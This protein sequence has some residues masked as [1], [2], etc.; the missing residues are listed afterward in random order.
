MKPLEM[1]D[2]GW[3]DEDKAIVCRTLWGEPEVVATSTQRTAIPTRKF[4]SEIGGE[5]D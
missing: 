4:T 1:P 3:S 5:D 2:N